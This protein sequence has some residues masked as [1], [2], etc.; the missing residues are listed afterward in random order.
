MRKLIDGYCRLLTWLMVA[1]VAILVVPVSLQ[2]ISRYTQL[3]PSYIWTEELSRFL[4]IWM[5][6]LG[7]MV[8]IKEGTHFEVD[9]WPELGRRANAM[10]R[11]VS[12]LFVLI[13]ALVFVYWGIKFV[14]F[15]WY[16]E[17][18]LAELPMPFIFVAWPLAGVTWARSSSTIFA[19]SPGR[20]RHDAGRDVARHGRVG[21]VR[22][23]LL[24]HRTAGAGGVCPRARVSAAAG[25]RAAALP[26]GTVQR[27]LQVLQLVH[28]AGGAVLPVDR[29]PDEY[30]RHHRSS[31]ASL[32]HD[33]RQLAGIA[34]ANQRASVRVLRRHFWLLHRRRREPEQNLH[35]GADQGRL[36]PVVLD[37]DHRGVGGAR[38]DHSALD[39]DDRLGW[40]AVGLDRRA[41]SR[42]HSARA[43]DR[44]RADGDRARLRQDLQ[45]SGLSARDL[46]RVLLLGGAVGAGADDAVHHRRWHPAG[47]V[48]R[49]RIGLRRGDLRG[50]AVDLRLPRDGRQAALPRIGRNRPALRRRAVLR[51]HRFGVRLDARLLPDPAGALGQRHRVG[52]GHHGSRLLHRRRVSGGRLFPRCNSGDHHRRHDA[53]AARPIGEH[54][55]GAIRRHRHRCARLRAG[56]AALWAV[57]HDLLRGRQGAAALRVERHDDHARAY[58]AGAGGDHRLAGNSAAP[59]AADLTRILALRRGMIGAGREIGAAPFNRRRRA[60]G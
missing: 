44:G 11:I 6:M 7:A 37:R 24:P 60:D 19:S 40:R 42:R 23:V 59:A 30:R 54:A 8:G 28:P 43:P 49:D 48:H 14:E 33:G 31:R 35:R 46:A 34:R 41:L 50:R 29:Q 9:I 27:N 16:Q 2:I 3:I 57:P 22:L 13:F 17:S 32:A 1:T 51:R 52:H 56:D 47:L 36:R 53:R 5:V 38:R 26:D 4:F 18:E 21:A 10:L 58:A 25:V 20:P 45:L 15:G 12:N 55:S 39:F